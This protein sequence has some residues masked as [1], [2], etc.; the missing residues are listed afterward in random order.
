MKRFYK[1]FFCF[2]QTDSKIKRCYRKH[3]VMFFGKVFVGN[4]LLAKHFV[5]IAVV[6][7]IIFS[8][9]IIYFS[10][11]RVFIGDIIHFILI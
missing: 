9:N 11:T 5:K 7:T 6:R 1:H 10:K 4:L 8:Y 2:G 3:L